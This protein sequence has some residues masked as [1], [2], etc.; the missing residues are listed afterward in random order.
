[1]LTA[2]LSGHCV[3]W[4]VYVSLPSCLFFF[5]YLFNVRTAV[6]VEGTLDLGGADSALLSY[7]GAQ[8]GSS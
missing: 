8:W 7:R 6:C 1:M 2:R 4:R 3:K 5:H